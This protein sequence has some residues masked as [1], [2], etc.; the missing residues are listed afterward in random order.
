MGQN[1]FVEDVNLFTT[2]LRYAPTNTISTINNGSIAN[3]RIINFA[4][5][6]R[7]MVNLTLL[8]RS[9]SSAKQIQ[10]FRTALER[11]VKDNPRV[12]SSVVVF[13]IINI[14][15]DTEVAEYRLR[16]QHQKSWQEMG[17]VLINQ[18][19]LLQFCMTLMTK[20][21]VGYDSP[22]SR[23]SVELTTRRG[24]E[25]DQDSNALPSLQ[26][27]ATFRPNRRQSS[28]GNSSPKK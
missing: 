16:V 9:N 25:T 17:S 22:K 20:L 5:S 14:D 15:P 10:L 28:I 21:G 1:W 11:Y 4:R 19:E 23:V 24:V 13:L 6:R 8:F 18:G 2:S 12:W 27:I 3:S 26:D 7:A